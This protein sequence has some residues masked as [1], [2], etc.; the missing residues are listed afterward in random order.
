MD[1]RFDELG[2]G[3]EEIR[4][5]RLSYTGCAKFSGRFGLDALRFVSS[6]KVKQCGCEAPSIPASWVRGCCERHST[7][8]T[9]G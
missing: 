7:P 1:H 6:P 4:R 8:L 9:P 3:L 2:A 5:T